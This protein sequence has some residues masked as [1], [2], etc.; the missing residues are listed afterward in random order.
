[1]TDL[2]PFC[3]HSLA[4]IVPALMLAGCSYRISDADVL[5]TT[6]PA[7]WYAQRNTLPLEL[8]GQVP[9]HTGVEIAALSARKLAE[10]TPRQR[11]VLYLDGAEQADES[12]LC[13]TPSVADDAP[14]A[15]GATIVTAVLCDGTDGI[16]MVRG[17]IRPG[18]RDDQLRTDLRGIQ[19]ELFRILYET[20]PPA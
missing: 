5:A 6:E 2:L 17:S 4:L 3:R 1:M 18:V 11:I 16:S 9:G 12:R 7:S 8:H 14:A 10:N 20:P 19:A 13:R 15:A